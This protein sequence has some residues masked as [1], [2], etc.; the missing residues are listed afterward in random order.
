MD[1]V[2]KF[3]LQT[4][5]ARLYLSVYVS[6]QGS[7][8]ATKG[9]FLLSSEHLIEIITKLH[10]TGATAVDHDHLDIDISDE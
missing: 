10:R 9:D 2:G 4:R 8:G 5:D 7:A 6:I 1:V 3:H